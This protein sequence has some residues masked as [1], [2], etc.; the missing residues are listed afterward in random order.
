LEGRED[1]AVLCSAA[2]TE[3]A[4][5]LA[6]WFSLQATDVMAPRTDWPEAAKGTRKGSGGEKRL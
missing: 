4:P 2:L 5:R 6:K 1:C 3:L